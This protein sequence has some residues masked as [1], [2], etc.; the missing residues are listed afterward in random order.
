M[1]VIRRV[2]LSSQLMRSGC[3]RRDQGI[4]GRTD[5]RHANNHNHHHHRH[6]HAYLLLWGDAASCQTAEGP[7]FR[8]QCEVACVC[9]CVCVNVCDCI[10]L[11]TSVCV[12][13][14]CCLHNSLPVS[15]HSLALT[16]H[17]SFSS[18]TSPLGLPPPP[19]SLTVSLHIFMNFLFIM[20]T[21]A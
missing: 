14:S 12:Y 3:S 19:P 2:G 8:L 9:V 11:C 21:Y 4:R 20:K 5:F 18:F 10:C 17:S 16:V 15:A 6:C 7:R 1:G 13:A